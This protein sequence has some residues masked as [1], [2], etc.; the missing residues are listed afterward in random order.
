MK[1]LAVVYISCNH[2]KIQNQAVFIASR[3][4]AVCKTT[5]VLTFD[6]LILLYRLCERNFF[7]FG[8]AGRGF[9]MS[10]VNKN[11]TRVHITRFLRHFLEYPLY[12][13]RQIFAHN[14]SRK[15]KNAA[16][17][18]STNSRWTTCAPR[19]L[20][21][22]LSFV[23]NEIEIYCLVDN[24]QQMIFR[25]EFFQTDCHIFFLQSPILL[26]VHKNASQ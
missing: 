7:A 10:R 16:R 11:C 17:V 13:C 2:F 25:H 9:Y 20:R 26:A 5:L 23:V 19:S 12:R 1:T 4:T 22:L 14:F 15:L 18:R 8:L 21:F 24:T 6:G 3:L